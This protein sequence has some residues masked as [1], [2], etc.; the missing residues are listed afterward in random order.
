M[1]MKKIYIFI[2]II[3]IYAFKKNFGNIFKL[4]K[5]FNF[6]F[7]KKIKYYIYTILNFY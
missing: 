1:V 4:Y 3:D 2:S 6:I 7:K 5:Y